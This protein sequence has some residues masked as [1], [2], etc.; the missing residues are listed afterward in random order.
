VFPSITRT[1]Y[2]DLVT[3]SVLTVRASKC[4]QLILVKHDVSSIL[5]LGLG[6]SNALLIA[7]DVGSASTSLLSSSSKS[8]AAADHDVWR[9]FDGHR[10]KQRFP[11]ARPCLYCCCFSKQKPSENVEGIWRGAN[12]LLNGSR[13][14]RFLELTSSMRFFDLERRPA[15]NNTRAERIPV[16]TFT[17]PEYHEIVFSCCQLRSLIDWTWMFKI[18]CSPVRYNNDQSQHSE[19][20]SGSPEQ[21]GCKSFLGVRSILDP[22][23][24]VMHSPPPEV[25]EL[26]PNRFL[27]IPIKDGADCPNQ[28]MTHQHRIGPP[29]RDGRN[30]VRFL[31]PAPICHHDSQIEYT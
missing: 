28:H 3:F 31:E 1:Q 8:Q 10:A 16:A 18:S 26:A 4:Y 27:A 14:A 2:S 23:I 30:V 21:P 13:L 19:C 9:L 5:D 22:N 15:N 29:R 24:V 20:L 6:C 25:S 7:C 12:Y 11:S 17:S